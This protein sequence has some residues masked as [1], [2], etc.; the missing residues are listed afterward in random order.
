MTFCPNCGPSSVSSG[1]RVASN[2]SWSVWTTTQR[3]PS[4][5]CL[6]SCSSVTAPGTSS[7]NLPASLILH[8]AEVLWSSSSVL[9]HPVAVLQDSR[10]HR[11][12]RR[13]NVFQDRGTHHH[14]L[15]SQH[16][17]V[18]D[19]LGWHLR[20][21]CG[22]TEP[23]EFRWWIQAETIRFILSVL[24]RKCEGREA[25]AVPQRA[26]LVDGALWAGLQETVHTWWPLAAQVKANSK[27]PFLYSETFCFRA[28]VTLFVM[29]SGTWS[30][31]CCS[32]SWRKARREPSCCC[33]TSHTSFLIKTWATRSLSSGEGGSA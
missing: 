20:W 25:G 10:W 9:W 29:L 8:R 32:K 24:N 1:L 17:C 16:I 13:T 28:G 27:Q 21:V 3:S 26:W 31:A 2:S 23:W 6:C 19:D 15:I 11:S 22:L 14:L 5:C 30:P 18:Q 4:S 12:L 7:R 33:S